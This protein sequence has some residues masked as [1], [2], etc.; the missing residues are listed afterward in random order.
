MNILLCG[1]TPQ[2][3]KPCPSGCS[4]FPDGWGFLS[5]VLY[6]VWSCH[7]E[8]GGVCSGR[9][10]A[11][12]MQKTVQCTLKLYLSCQMIEARAVIPHNFALG[13]HPNPGQLQ[14]SLDA[15]GKGTV[16]VRVIDGHD[17]IVITN[18]VDDDVEQFLVHIRTNKALTSK[19]FAWQSREWARF[20]AAIFLPLMLQA[21]Q[22]PR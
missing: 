22:P 5:A 2:E 14:E 13:F 19:I 6:H 18:S 1:S 9:L 4:S 7:R 10:H 17:D 21:M 20:A 16:S 12:L 15:M 11:P 3:P 8:G